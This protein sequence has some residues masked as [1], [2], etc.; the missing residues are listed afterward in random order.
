MSPPPHI[1]LRVLDH[2][3]MGLEIRVYVYV[4]SMWNTIEFSNK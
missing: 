2:W 1:G 4:V 3:T